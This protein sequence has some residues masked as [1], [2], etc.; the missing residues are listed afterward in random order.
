MTERNYEIML[1]PGEW[2]CRQKKCVQQVNDFLFFCT[3]SLEIENRVH[4]ENTIGFTMIWKY[5]GKLKKKTKNSVACS[6]LR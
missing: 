6:L 1:L 3:N 5:L 4:F 2:I